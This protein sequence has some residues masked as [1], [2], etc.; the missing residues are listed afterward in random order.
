[1]TEY[2]DIDLVLGKGLSVSDM[3]SFSSQSAISCIAV[4]PAV[5][6]AS[7]GGRVAALSEALHTRRGQSQVQYRCVVP[8]LGAT[9]QQPEG[10]LT[11]VCERFANGLARLSCSAMA[12]AA[13]SRACRAEQHRAWLSALI[14]GIVFWRR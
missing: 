2:R 6:M 12:V 3:P 11:R 1:M 7:R 4:P 5:G 9:L 14:R 8:M 10:H 13:S